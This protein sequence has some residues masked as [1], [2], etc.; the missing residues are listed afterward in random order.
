MDLSELVNKPIEE[1][2][3]EELQKLESIGQREY[4][5][6]WRENNR[7]KNKEIVK[8]ARIK[9]GLRTLKESGGNH[10]EVQSPKLKASPKEPGNQASIIIEDD[11]LWINKTYRIKSNVA[12]AFKECAAQ[13]RFTQTAALEEAMRDWIAKNQ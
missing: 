7:D 6:K 2:T 3:E 1:M 12:S 10:V 13:N 8:R 9:K 11:F 5:R 4:N